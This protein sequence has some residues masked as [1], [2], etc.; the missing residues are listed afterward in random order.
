MTH[1]CV[2]QWNEAQSRPRRTE[3]ISW[4]TCA[5]DADY[6]NVVNGETLVF[7][8]KTTSEGYVFASIAVSIFLRKSNICLTIFMHDG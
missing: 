3:N 2:L 4:H 7:N 1:D 5:A 6:S 8:D